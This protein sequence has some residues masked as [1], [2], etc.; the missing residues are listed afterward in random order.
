MTLPARKTPNPRRFS[1]TIIAE[2]LDKVGQKD[3][4]FRPAASMQW[5]KT[6]VR[7]IVLDKPT[8]MKFGVV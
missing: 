1:Y 8:Y 4:A 2:A 6:S 3:P 5:A 7:G